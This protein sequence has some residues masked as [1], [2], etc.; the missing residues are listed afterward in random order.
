MPLKPGTKLG[1]Y[2]IVSLLGAGGMGEVYRARDSRLERDVAIK[3]LLA[4]SSDDP[5]AKLRFERE[6]KAV[7]A[8]QHPN[9]LNIFD[10]V[11]TPEFAYAV[12]ELLE[13]D[14]LRAHISK[15][16]L[17]QKK[18]VDVAIKVAQGIA[19]AHSKGIVHRDLKPENI[20]ITK[21]GLPKILDFG[22][23]KKAVQEDDDDSPTVSQPGIVMG[24]IGY[25][26]PEQLR[27]KDADN[28]SDIFSFGAVLYEM[29]SGK[30]AFKSDTQAETIS[31]ILK[32]DPPDLTKY[33]PNF[34]PF[35]ERVIRRCLEKDPKDRFQ[36]T[37]DL[38]FALESFGTL[39]TGALAVQKGA[40]TPAAAPAR[41][42]PLAVLAA[43]A[44]VLVAGLLF[45]G[46]T[47]GK[48]SFSEPVFQRLA[49]RRGTI[50]SARFSPDGQTV[51]YG[52]AWDGNP[53]EPFSTIPGSTES[54][55]LN[56]PGTEILD[57]S[58][59]GEMALSLKRQPV[60]IFERAGTLARAPLAGGTPREIAEN[61]AFA[62]W[63]PDGK[64]LAITRRAGGKTILE[65]PSG[66]VLYE[67]TGWIGNP[68]VSPK[69]DMVA[70][71]DYPSRDSG[72][73]SVAVVDVKGTKKVLSEGW[74]RVQGLAWRDS[75]VWFAGTRAGYARALT[76]VTLSGKERLVLRVTG[77][78]TLHDIASDGRVL[79]SFENA[80][81][82][83]RCLPPGGDR[84]IDLSWLDYSVPKDLSGDGS[85]VLFHENGEGG[86]EKWGLYVRKTDGTPA[87]RLGEGS[88]LNLSPDG[89]WA[90]SLTRKDRR[91]VLLPTGVG[92]PKPLPATA[93]KPIGNTGWYI[94]QNTLLFLG[95]KEGEKP[96]L[97]TMAADGTNEKSLTPEGL[98]QPALVESPV[99]P[100]QK[101]LVVRN[102]E[103]GLLS[104]PLEGGGQPT[105][106]AGSLPGDRVVGWM[107]DSSEAFVVG[108][109]SLPAKVAKLNLKT[110]QR[111]LWKELQPLDPAG[112]V[113][114]DI[115]RVS[116]DG[117]AYVYSYIRTLSDLYQVS[118]LK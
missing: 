17:S 16:S 19:A 114:V 24:T 84:E 93:A 48:S 117:R 30:R 45:A 52:G 65:Y 111:T 66:K 97:Y 44:A 60:S 59:S 82:E 57:I 109:P 55:S 116:L 40:E 94:D 118:G 106:V 87:V 32:E 61:V 64:D 96:R 81:R 25:M 23:A 91:Y 15:Q 115:T 34:P 67:T 43:G 100:D 107:F 102:S 37:Q 69:G 39:T 74:N 35:L 54:R 3:V 85:V 51:I 63:S 12:M 50:E 76:A 6:A 99:A 73:G 20:F 68:Q 105:K 21:E 112:V 41:K 104:L 70:F 80:R 75:E 10:F 8:L 58:P 101:T 108:N 29:F 33:D 2:S 113:S 18:L 103:Q 79:L 7:A 27:G 49:F 26:A 110:G 56:L 1:Q 11:V 42:I 46:F 5:E 14:T 28:R 31:A 36:S 71:L 90:F 83:M 47:L 62:S 95:Q 4:L 38:V 78:L 53:V 98:V 13:G 22:L 77:P 88:A 72:A 89:K 92:S 86:G 9:I